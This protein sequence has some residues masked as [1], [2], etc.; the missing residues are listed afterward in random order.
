MSLE[1]SPALPATVTP[2]FTVFTPTRNRAHTLH[3]A[4]ESLLAQSFTDFEWL[5]VD[6]GSTD[7]T[8]ELVGGWRVAAGFP[9]RYIVQENAG[10]HGSWARA[11]AEARG[12]LLLFT[13]SA[14]GFVSNALERFDSIWRSI[15]DDDRAG[16]SGVT[17]NCVDEHGRLIGT[18]FPEPVLD[19][20]S[21][22]IR[23]RY[24]VKGEKWGFQRVDVMRE[25]PLPIIQ[26]YLG[27]MPEAII[28]RAIGRNY[29]TRFV[30][31]SLRIYWQDQKTSNAGSRIQTRALGG[32]LEAQSLL[33]NDM[34]WFRYDPLAFLRKGAK[35]ARC[36]FH[37]GWTAGTQFRQLNSPA[38][39][40]VWVAT[41]LVGWVFYAVDRCRGGEAIDRLPESSV[42]DHDEQTYP[43]EG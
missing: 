21:S 35:Y 34:R 27:Y 41:V 31:E 26:G 11:V 33:N 14:D 24:R 17:V 5:I 38:A 15:P 43:A 2:R 30:N 20:N 29:R 22:E 23:F 25:H 32:L 10:V 3:R 13:R 9:I 37:V 36:S 4:Y 16:F 12:E 7:G 18:E 6:N 8:A 19:S 39:R 28:W 42:L 1:P 40:A